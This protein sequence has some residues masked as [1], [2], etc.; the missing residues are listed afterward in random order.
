M[1]YLVLQWFYI[2]AANNSDSASTVLKTKK[3]STGYGLPFFLNP[4]PPIPKKTPGLFAANNIEK[5]KGHHFNFHDC[6]NETHANLGVMH[7]RV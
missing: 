1:N 2:T 5:H 6:E 3:L 4:P 7:K